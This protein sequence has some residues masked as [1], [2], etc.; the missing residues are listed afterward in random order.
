MRGGVS[1][2]AAQAING[3]AAIVNYS[4]AGTTQGTATA[5]VADTNIITTAASG[6]GVILYAGMP[7]DSQLVYNADADDIKVYPP[8]GAA[9]NQLSANAGFVLA[10]Y[11]AV[12]CKCVSATQW[13]GFLS[14]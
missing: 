7:G 13:L 9:I 3:N 2:G 5:I 4:A 1:A 11:T 6:A 10:P 12:E 8:S 14:A